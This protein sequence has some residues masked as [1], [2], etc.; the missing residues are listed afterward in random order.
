MTFKTVLVPG[1]AWPAS[2][3]PK[4]YK[5][6]FRPGDSGSKPK[7]THAQVADIRQRREAGASY[8]VLQ[9]LFKTSRNTISSVVLK[10]GTYAT[11]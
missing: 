10:T 6:R 8:I 5:H 2:T 1:V 11:Y 7:L 3:T 9:A 4:P